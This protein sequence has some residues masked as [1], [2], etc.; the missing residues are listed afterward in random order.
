M[1][2]A[3]HGQ[4]RT[5]PAEVH[6]PH[7]GHTTGMPS[8]AIARRQAKASASSV[9]VSA[10]ITGAAATVIDSVRV[11]TVTESGRGALGHVTTRPS[12]WS[13]RRS[14]AAESNWLALQVSSSQMRVHHL[15][16]ILDTEGHVPHTF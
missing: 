12:F 5:R 2:L 7:D 6:A 15:N 9:T 11:T 8:F 10:I 14:L 16:Y 3:P 13:S 1:P 4:M